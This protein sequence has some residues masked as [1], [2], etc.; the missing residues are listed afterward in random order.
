MYPA[1]LYPETSRKLTELVRATGMSEA[2][3]IDKSLTCYA[4]LRTVLW[5]SG[6]GTRGEIGKESE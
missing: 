5:A 6:P 1:Q 3:L 4:I 2:E